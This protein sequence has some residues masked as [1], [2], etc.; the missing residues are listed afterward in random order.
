MKNTIVSLGLAIA[1]SS[2]SAFTITT[3][4]PSVDTSTPS[5]ITYE[6]RA[7]DS[8]VNTGDYRQSWN[9]QGSTIYT[10]D[11]DEFTNIRTY[12][13]RNQHSHLNINFDVSDSSSG[14]DWWFQ[15]SP[16]AGHGGAVYFDGLLVDK[17]TNDLWWS[18]QWNRTNELL[19]AYIDDLGAGTHSIDMYW[20]E[21]CCNGGQSGRFSVDNGAN[22]YALT[23]E[24]L[25][26]VGVSEPG[27]LALLGL[28]LMGLAAV[29]KKRQS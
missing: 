4:T 6:Q 22:W 14:M 1:A 25:D 23:T 29:R 19:T 28:G 2:A 8:G 24:N 7:T 5:S 27:S 17:D 12:N 18:G 21:N 10:S 15:F 13:N 9:N 20:A 26:T 3:P 11:L 16:D